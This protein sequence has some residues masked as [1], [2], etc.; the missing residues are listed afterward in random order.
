[1]LLAFT[2]LGEMLTW[3]EVNQLSEGDGVACAARVSCS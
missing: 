2:P 1:M 3:L